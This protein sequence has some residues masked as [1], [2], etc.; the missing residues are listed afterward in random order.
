MMWQVVFRDGTIRLM[1]VSQQR[2]RGPGLDVCTTPILYATMRVNVLI[3]EVG[4]LAHVL[5]S[6]SI[7]A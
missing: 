7:Y 5:R 3:V 1:E 4:R 2:G 6:R